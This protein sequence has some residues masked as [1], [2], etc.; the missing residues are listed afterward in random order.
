[1]VARAAEGSVRDA[2]SIFDQAI[3]HGAGSV[4]AE[5]V[6]AMLGLCDRARV[7][8]LFEQLMKGDVAAALAE[9]RASTTP[10]PT[11][12]PCSP[13]SPSSTTS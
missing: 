7:I 2:L 4:S 5:A 9:F 12:R 10:A 13:T 1:M 6:R 8:D 11:R 3:A